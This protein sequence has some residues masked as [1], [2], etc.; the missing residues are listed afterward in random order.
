[1]RKRLGRGH[2]S[3][4]GTF[5]GRGIKGQRARTGGKRKLTQRALRAFLSKAPKKRGFTSGREKYDIVTL[6][7]LNI[8]FSD[9]ESVT[10]TT[11]AQK[12]F[13][14]SGDRGIKVLGIEELKKKLTVRLHAF[15][16]AARRSILKAGGTATV[17]K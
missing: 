16:N 6:R 11:L 10:P 15:S 9:G 1:M 2:G 7:Q 3:G 17:I 8:W 12:G 4:R 5:A 13:R 14:T